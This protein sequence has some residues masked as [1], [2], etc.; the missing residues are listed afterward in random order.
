[1]TNF[2]AAIFEPLNRLLSL[3]ASV[4][5]LGAGFAGEPAV[6][7]GEPLILY[8][9]EGCPFC[10]IARE[11]VSETGVATLVRPCPKGGKRFRPRVRELGGKTQFPYLV[12]LNTDV[13][14]YESA[15]IA[16]YL[17]KTYGKRSASLFLWLGPLNGVLSAFGV[18]ARLY[19]GTFARRA[20]PPERPLEFIG[21]ERDPSAR[22]V[23][24][25]LCELELDYVWRP[26]GQ[27]GKGAPRLKDP[28]TGADLKGAMTI[29][30][31]IAR[32]YGH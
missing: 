2:L 3:L 28:N 25:L 1:M 13:S 7:P 18:M 15:D 23:K 20:R 19:A 21:A 31:Y 14:M 22:L 27:D 32:T 8:E 6:E 12:D 29:R 24:E 9:F 26:R 11:A 5:R 30:Q 16:R 17:Y 4:L 10:R